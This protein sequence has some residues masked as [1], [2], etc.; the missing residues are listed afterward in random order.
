MNYGELAQALAGVVAVTVT[1]FTGEERRID[2]LAL[3][4]QV[5]FLVDHGIHVL[6]TG[7]NTGE[8]YS[9]TPEECRRLVD[10]AV[11]EVGAEAVILAGIGHD[12]ATAAEMARAAERA[13]AHGVMVHSPVHPYLSA[14]GLTDYYQAITGAVE[15]GVVPYVRHPNIDEAVLTALAAAPNVVG[16]KYAI[17]ELQRFANLV[18]RLPAAQ[19]GM[20]WVCGTAEAWAPFFFAAGASGFTSGLVNVAPQKALDLLAALQAGDAGESMRVWAS[21]RPF[22]ALR[23]RNNSEHNVSVVKAAQALLGLG[24]A[25]VRPPNAELSDATAGEVAAVLRDWGLL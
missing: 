20:T 24:S 4:R 5:R 18:Q 8:F 21:I 17:N 7:G 10:A 1:P 14:K 11:A 2:D 19:T 16:C 6:V 25:A 22:E 12:A 3:R 15:I 23:A 13:G 9:L